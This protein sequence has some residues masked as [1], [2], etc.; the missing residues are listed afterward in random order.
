MGDRF[1]RAARDGSSRQGLALLKEATS[2][3]LN[4][5]DKEG[6]TPTLIAAEQGHLEAVKICVQRGGKCHSADAFGQTGLHLATSK[7]HY[8]IVKFIQKYYKDEFVKI[9]FL[10]D[11]QEMT[12]KML[13]AGKNDQRITTTLDRAEADLRQHEANAVAKAEK[14][15]L[16]LMAENKKRFET[17]VAKQ[18][19]KQQNDQLK[20]PVTRD[21]RQTV[22]YEDGVRK[23]A[24]K[25]EDDFAPNKRKQSVFATI[26]KAIGTIK[27]K[28][29]LEG[30]DFSDMNEINGTMTI[31]A[32]NSNVL[33]KTANKK[34]AELA[35]NGATNGGG[36]GSVNGRTDVRNIFDLPNDNDYEDD[37]YNRPMNPTAIFASGGFGQRIFFRQNTAILSQMEDIGG[38]DTGGGFIKPDAPSPKPD[39]ISD[40]SSIDSDDDDDEEIDPL[41]TFLA[42]LNLTEY[43]PLFKKE[44]MDL[45]ALMVAT[46]QDL[47]QIGLGKGPRIKILRSMDVRRRDMEVTTESGDTQ[48]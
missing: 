43:Y 40:D 37:E 23:V 45:D 8:Q 48:F 3:D 42:A 47:H 22:V 24:L 7:G 28:Q 20:Q 6:M 30:A 33:F 44:R 29:I 11:N 41:E 32:G 31:S 15:A 5:R 17:I 16:K 21:K 4:R 9:L 2:R 27:K 26:G 18:K 10:L 14:K 19:K 35:T 38:K 25:D 34:P 1:H 12:A 46:D 13:A 39:D 36:G